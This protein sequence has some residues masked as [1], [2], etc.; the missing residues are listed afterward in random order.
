MAYALLAMQVVMNV[1]EQLLQIVVAAW[2]EST[3]FFF[4]K[5]KLEENFLSYFSFLFILMEIRKTFI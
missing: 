2:M 4:L 3:F 1:Q 5:L